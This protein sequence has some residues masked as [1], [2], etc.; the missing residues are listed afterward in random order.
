M[1]E[2]LTEALEERLA[3]DLTLS[4]D[5]GSW[6]TLIGRCQR[7]CCPSCV[8]ARSRAARCVGKT[9]RVTGMPHMPGEP[10]AYDGIT[11]LGKACANPRF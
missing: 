8:K 5:D 1:D 11:V 10:P 3:N 9:S 6:L 4:D 2:Y 7:L